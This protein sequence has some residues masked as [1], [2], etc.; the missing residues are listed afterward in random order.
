MS[1]KKPEKDFEQVLCE[2]DENAARRKDE[3][4]MLFAYNMSPTETGRRVKG[5]CA[6]YPEVLVCYEDGKIRAEYPTG[7][8][9]GAYLS[10]DGGYAKIVLKSGDKRILCAAGDLKH[11][12]RFGASAGAMDRY[13][14]ERTFV[15]PKAAFTDTVCPKCGRPYPAGGRVCKNCSGKKQ[16]F[17][18]MFTMIR[19]A[20]PLLCVSLVL[21]VG[22]S[23][24]GL[25]PPI[26]SEKMVDG[27]LKNEGASSAMVWAYLSVVAAFFGVIAAQRL[28]AALRSALTVRIGTKTA[29]RLRASVFEKVQALSLSGVNRR[30]AGELMQRVSSDTD[31]IGNFLVHVFGNVV[32]Q[33]FT[34]AAIGVI[35]L[36]SGFE[37]GTNL[38]LMVFLPVIPAALVFRLFHKKI[39]RIYRMLWQVS[40]KASARMHDIFS[41]IRVVKTYG[42]EKEEIGRYDRS[43][44]SVKIIQKR[45]ETFW[46]VLS[47]MVNFLL[48]AGEFLVLYVV[49]NKV[50]GGNMTLGEMTKYSSYAAMI[51][52]P[53]RAMTFLPRR[54]AQTMTSVSKIYDLINDEDVMK[55]AAQAHDPVITGRV[56]LCGVT[57]GYEPGKDVL[58]RVDLKIEPGEMI[59]LVGRSGVGKSTLTNL[60]MRLYDVDEGEVKLDG[61]N[62]RD[63]SRDC[64]R[65]TVGAVLQ[66][67]FL[68]SGSIRQNI[69]YAKPEATGEE[70]VAAAKLAGAHEFI[71]KMPDGYDSYVGEKGNTLSGGEKQRIAIARALLHDPKILILDEATSALDTETEK[72]IQDA[73]ARLISGRTTIAIAHRLSTLRN[74]TRIVVLDDKGIAEQGS[75]EE[76]M[77]NDKGIYYGLVMAQ[78]KMTSGK[79]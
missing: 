28:I 16:Q 7:E 9:D 41:G 52:S 56:E 61:V 29:E 54:V 63:L 17:R 78:R 59:G 60:V 25:I 18:W 77:R 13:F 1:K 36:F 6:L 43:I 74:A 48:C 73:L 51:Y 42:K 57:F 67:T 58:R 79:K 76:L 44:T 3:R 65:R 50:L 27:Y 46:G 8:L 71:M 33:V 62:I 14:S 19:P 10:A 69:A 11:K 55:Q 66:E 35:F 24:L 40:A 34:L 45:N 2:W 64:L 75:H 39:H 20:L 23:A 70:I 5:L 37:G 68:F 49:G 21:F 22:F 32:E 15:K 53:L 47:P 4:L 30:T 26:L 12:K 72:Q 38:F 31:I